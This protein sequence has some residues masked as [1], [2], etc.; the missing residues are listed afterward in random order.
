MTVLKSVATLEAAADRHDNV[1]HAFTRLPC[2]SRKVL[3][4]VLI[5]NVSSLA[6]HSNSSLHLLTLSSTLQTTE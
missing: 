1:M 5:C 2:C 4:G 3:M 6:N